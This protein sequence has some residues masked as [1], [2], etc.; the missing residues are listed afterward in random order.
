V[1]KRTSSVVT[2]DAILAECR[3]AVQ[4]GL[5]RKVL[6]KKAA[7]YW[8]EGHR[9]A[10]ARMFVN[11]QSPN[12]DS[13]KKHVLPLARRLGRVAAGLANKGLVLLWAAEAAHDA[14]RKDPR[15]PKT[16]RGGY[17]DF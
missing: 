3:E 11:G 13:E 12:W 7:D 15:C 8:E 2:V 4:R 10:V 6:T 17:C 16:G 5:G 9:Q 14:I 1:A